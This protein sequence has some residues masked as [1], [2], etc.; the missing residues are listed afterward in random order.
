M[1]PGDL[2][3]ILVNLSRILLVLD[4]GDGNNLEGNIV[5]RSKCENNNETTGV[6]EVQK[7]NNLSCSARGYPAIP[8]QGRPNSDNGE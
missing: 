4:Y 5:D 6:S 7:R 1:P 3:S 2:G 8:T